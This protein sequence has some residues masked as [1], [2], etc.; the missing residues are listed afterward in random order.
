M[1]RHRYDRFSVTLHWLM[2]ALL[3]GQIAPL[4][5]GVGARE[6]AM[7]ALARPLAMSSATLL[8]MAVLQ[9]VLLVAALPLALGGVR[10]VR[11]LRG[12]R[13]VN[14]AEARNTDKNTDTHT[15]THTGAATT[16]WIDAD[17]GRDEPSM[18]SS[19]GSSPSSTSPP[20][21]HPHPHPP[22]HGAAQ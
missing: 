12:E 10:L 6:A 16:D 17:M 21:S 20:H 5:G 7:I 2:A 8:A 9:R 15:D 13:S 18:P 19:A 1:Q 4:P 3:L 14:L 11:R 22:T